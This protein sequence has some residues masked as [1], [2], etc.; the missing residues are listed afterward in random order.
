M[1]LSQVEGRTYANLF[2]LVERFIGAKMIEVGRGHALGDQ[3]AFEAIVRFTDEEL[4]HQALFQRIEEML[5]AQMPAGYACAAEP[6]AVAAAVLSKSTWAVLALTCHIELFT[7]AHY[8]ASIA[9]DETLWPPGTCSCST[10]ARSRSTRSSTSSSGSAR[11]RSC[12]PQS[13]TRRSTT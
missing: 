7:Q 12:R 2:G 10:G 11:T 13:A 8:R 5:A 4:K 9:K 1:A 6:N 3:T